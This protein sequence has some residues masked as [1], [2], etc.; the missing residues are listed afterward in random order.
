M[1]GPRS[2]TMAPSPWQ[3][4][5]VLLL[6]CLT[7]VGSSSS[8]KLTLFTGTC[9]GTLRVCQDGEAAYNVVDGKRH[10]TCQPNAGGRPTIRLSTQ[11]WASP[12]IMSWL[13]EIIMGEQL[14][15]PVEF[16]DSEAKVRAVDFFKWH[17][18]AESRVEQFMTAGTPGDFAGIKRANADPTCKSGGEGG[19]GESCH[20]AFLETWNVMSRDIKQSVLVDQYAEDGGPNGQF[21]RTGIFTQEMAAS[22]FGGLDYRTMTD[23]AIM[24]RFQQPLLFRDYCKDVPAAK[25]GDA[26]G[27][28]CGALYGAAGALK[29]DTK[30]DAELGAKFFVQS[31]DELPYISG[32]IQEGKVTGLKAPAGGAAVYEGS[33]RAL[34]GNKAFLAE[35]PC[36]LDTF[37]P[38]QILFGSV[39]GG[40]L[41]VQR[42]QMTG[43]PQ[44]ENLISLAGYGHKKGNACVCGGGGAGTGRG[45]MA[46][47]TGGGGSERTDESG[48]FVLG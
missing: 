8:G 24:S 31:M 17:D 44:L 38:S 37:L 13:V 5:P 34:P 22:A 15:I 42:V 47:V 27:L 43:K 10:R 45:G 21:G 7:L 6:A 40:P 39:T 1:Q 33:F 26:A 4:L 14:Q 29:G 9:T 16:S 36:M 28:L 23:P 19:K 30:A 48:M 11:A 46:G 25:N 35:P 12:M 18:G 2:H 41:L 20:H 32:K 3:F